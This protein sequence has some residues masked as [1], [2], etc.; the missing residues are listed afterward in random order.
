ML[1]QD[2]F[3][4][5]DSDFL[6]QTRE[7][8]SQFKVVSELR[9]RYRSISRALR[10]SSQK[11]PECWHVVFSPDETKF[12]WLCGNHKVVLVPWNRSKNCLLDLDDKDERGNEIKSN[13]VVIDAGS[14]VNSVAF[15]TGT[16]EEHLFRQESGRWTRFNFSRDL[17]LA[18]GHVNGRIRIWDAFSGHVLLELMDHTDAVRD[19]A[20]APDGSLRLVSGSLDKSLKIWDL[21]DDGNMI[22][23][24]SGHKS[25]VFWC[26]WS[27]TSV[28]MASCGS[29]NKVI[30]WDM[31]RYKIHQTLVGHYNSVMA[32]D[33]SPDGAILATASRDT[34]V[35]LWDP[36]SG[37]LLRTLYHVQ[38]PPSFIFASGA[39]GAWIRGIAYSRDGMHIGTV[40]EGGLVRFWNLVDEERDIPMVKQCDN[41]DEE[42]ELLCCSVSPSGRTLAVGN[43][44]SRVTFYQVPRVVGTLKHL[45][46]MAVRKHLESP[47]IDNI[48]LPTRLT[49]YLKYHLWY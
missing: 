24:L 3:E 40:S 49:E 39:N 1:T 47:N 4:Y 10:Q 7:V 48:L 28:Y 15:G 44:E 35:I 19:I 13:L 5:N 43:S 23:T 41:N 32:C 45:A 11:L 6:F 33:F 25:H 12:A 20:F 17:V 2:Y 9:P 30:V 14:P 34:R 21:K 38:P 26:T 22:K 27:P 37:K 8:E 16:P 18:T 46:R 36:A 29:E 42:E 31:K